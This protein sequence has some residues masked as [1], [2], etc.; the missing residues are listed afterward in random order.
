MSNNYYALFLNGYSD[1]ENYLALIRH[2][3][4]PKSISLPHIT[5]FTF[6]K[7]KIARNI[8]ENTEISSIN[9]VEPGT[10][11][12]E[13][14]NGKHVIYLRCE[15]SEID[16]IQY[17]PDFPSSRLHLTLYEGEDYRYAVKLFD[18]IDSYRWHF[19]ISFS[20]PRRVIK[21][22]IGG[23]KK[24]DLTF[25]NAKSIFE[26]YLKESYE[27]FIQKNCNETK[28]RLIKEI[29]RQLKISVGDSNIVDSY[30]L[31]SLKNSNY[32][33][34]KFINQK[35]TCNLYYKNTTSKNEED[36]HHIT[37]PDYARDMAELGLKYLNNEQTYIHFGD[38]EVGTGML[39]LM[40]MQV[41]KQTN[42]SE[43]RDLKLLS[44]IGVEIDRTMAEETY[45][46]CGKRGLSVI[47]GDALSPEVNLG[48][49]RNLILANPPYLK[50]QD[51]DENYKRILHEIVHDQLGIDL[52]GK[53]DLYMYHFLLMKKWLCKDGISVW[54]LPNTCLQSN[55]ALKLREFLLSNVEL[56]HIHLYNL[57]DQFDNANVSTSI[58]IYKNKPCESNSFLLTYG[59][60]A[61]NPE[62]EKRVCKIEL[63][64]NINSWIRLIYN[65]VYAKNKF[66]V[67][68]DNLKFCDVFTIKR[69]IATGA[70]S[71]FV[72][73]RS[74]AKELGIPEIALK[75]VIPK[76]IYMSDNVIESY[77]DGKPKV[78][79]ELVLI[80]CNLDE[81]IIKKKYPEFYNYL[82]FGKKS[83]EG[84]KA[85]IDNT[86]V[87]S[88]RLWYKQETR[89]VPPYLFTYMGRKNQKSPAL[90]FF[91]NKSKA[92][93]LNNYILLYPKKWVL[94][95]IN[96]N[97]TLYEEILIS[98][99]ISAKK[100]I[101]NK[102]RLYSGGLH[103]IEPGELRNMPILDLP[104]IIQEKYKNTNNTDF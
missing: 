85:V 5:L 61:L 19:K 40:L 7:E 12:F 102:T 28:L 70:N 57:D 82:Q 13:K 84:K 34:A 32:V 55:Y 15:S 11:N 17:K 62:Y 72:L 97:S 47:H 65:D 54:L 53:T 48:S 96:D 64:E 66:S 22:V 73:E 23:E 78:S 92:I 79:P 30:Y 52:Q 41:I 2:I 42:D 44:S 35:E 75:Y 6:K 50:E 39:F 63:L 104:F 10:F 98:L 21:D 95:L 71:F 67:R 74:R 80:D 87:R 24:K 69:G 29:L 1:I 33:D 45:L 99:N 8:V 86:L 58:I 37:P 68:S 18:I 100:I 101:V 94:D 91:L 16:A 46:K 31:K 51:I 20:K 89:E 77:E 9:I 103:K 88:R 38:P 93:A 25:Y 4:N 36:I 56:Q 83:I 60:S 14:S 49:C 59:R 43:N 76:A 3:C 81:S 90:R 26:R 27:E